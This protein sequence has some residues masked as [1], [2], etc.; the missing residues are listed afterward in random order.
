MGEF[1]KRGQSP[2]STAKVNP[3]HHPPVTIL[4]QGDAKKKCLI[5]KHRPHG[6]QGDAKKK[7]LIVKHRPH[8][9]VP[10]ALDL[11]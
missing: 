5:V 9:F 8:G 11:F 2:L 1:A 6:L 7:C 3:W 4:I 10:T